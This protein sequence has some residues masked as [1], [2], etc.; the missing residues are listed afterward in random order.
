[1]FNL[2][3][4]TYNYTTTTTS[5]SGGG[6]GFGLLMI[7]YFA[8]LIVGIVALWKVFQK[9]GEPGWAAIIPIYNMYVLLK[10]AGRPGWW[11]LLLLVPFVNLIVYVVLSLDIAK[12]FGKS[13]LFGIVGLW[14]FSFIGYLILGFG[15]AKYV[16]GGTPSAGSAAPTAPPAAPAP[17]A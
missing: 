10:I 7:I 17:V 2:A 14:L 5:S 13:Q 1:M 6:A 12:N 11:L 8:V 15:D 16:G 4:V 9:A 3:E